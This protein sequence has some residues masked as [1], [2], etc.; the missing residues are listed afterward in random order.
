MEVEGWN[1]QAAYRK[2][3]DEMA[4]AGY[5]GTGLGLYGYLPS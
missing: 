4:E 1:G 2:V 3:L 5:E